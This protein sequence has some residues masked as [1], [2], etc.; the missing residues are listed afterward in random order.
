ME[1][2]NTAGFVN[3]ELKA[4]LDAV[5]KDKATERKAVQLEYGIYTFCGNAGLLFVVATLLL[6]CFR[7]TRKMGAAAAAGLIVDL[8]V[9]NVTIKP[10]V[11]RPRPW[12]TMAG[13][14]NLLTSS[15]PNSFPSGHTCAAFAFAAAICMTAPKKWMKA[16]A[17][18]VAIQL[19]PY[20]VLPLLLAPLMDRLP[21]KAFLVAGDVINGVVYGAMGFWLLFFEFSYVGYLVIS[22]LLACLG[23]LRSLRERSAL[24]GNALVN[25]SLLGIFLLLMIW[26]AGGRYFFHFMP[27]LILAAALSLGRIA[28]G[29]CVR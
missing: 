10:L 3:D 21:R 1:A 27:V 12:L 7:R 5:P 8:L 28:E 20:F 15:D 17:L 22:L 13:F 6:L 14:Q 29:E 16:A 18:I 9:V 23:C 11:S 19:I 25:I 4:R 2:V 24:P 26:E